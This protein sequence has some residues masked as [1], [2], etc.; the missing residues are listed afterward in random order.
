MKSKM[1]YVVLTL[2]VFM[3]FS[4]ND[5]LELIPPSGLIRDEFWKS[6][7]DVEAVLMASYESFGSMDRNLFLYGELRADL[8]Q[9][10]VN[11]SDDERNVM[12]SNIYPSNSFASWS[13]LYKVINYCNEVIKNAPL[14]QGID[15]TFTDFQLRSL[16]SEAVFLRSLAYFYLVRLYRDV[17]LVLDPSESDDTDF[18]LPQTPEDAVLEQ[19]AGDLTANRDFAPT[20]SFPTIEENKGRASKAAFDALLA[21]IAL[22]RFQYEEALTHIQ[23]IEQNIEF[24]MMPSSRWFQIF[25][26]GNSLESIFEFQFDG[27]RNQRNNTFGLTE[28]NAYQYDPSQ[29]SVEMFGRE[30]SKEIVRGEGATIAKIGDDNYLIWKYVGQSPDGLSVRAGAQQYSANWVVYRLADV[31][32]M[33]AEALS[34]LDRYN[35]AL[36]IIN[37]IRERANVQP[38]SIPFNKVAFEDAILEERALEL[39]YEGKRWFDLLRMGRRNNFSRKSKLIEIIVSNVPSTQKRILSAKLTNPSGWYLPIQKDEIERNRNLVQNPYYDF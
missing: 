24:E 26:P 27:N 17:P 7:E 15:N 34:Q 19:I 13:N 30:F 4:C 35:E 11:Q 28:Q 6:K 1:K 20:E 21:E 25:Y 12:E 23:K 3:Q 2:L 5:W 32:L 36:T 37:E 31:L 8:L 29:A 22:W 18:Y 9:G 33:K 39:A 14:V 16:V 38:V 10:D